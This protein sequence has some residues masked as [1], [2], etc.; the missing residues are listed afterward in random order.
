[1][2]LTLYT[3]LLYPANQHHHTPKRFYLSGFISELQRFVWYIV[4]L[5]NLNG[6]EDLLFP[7]IRIA[8]RIKQTVEWYYQKKL[9]KKVLFHTNLYIWHTSIFNIHKHICTDTSTLVNIQVF[10]YTNKNICTNT[11]GIVH[12]LVYIYTLTSIYVHT[13]VFCTHT[14][15]CVYTQIYM[16]TQQYIWTYT[17][18]FVQTPVDMYTYQYICA[19]TRICVYTEVFMC[20]HEY[21]CTH[22]SIYVH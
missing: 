3:H 13:T 22:T 12:R 14:S 15:I 7:M 20:T 9:M 17:N 11:R 8:L 5:L 18:K 4:N 2:L 6:F 19:H 16:C 1:M 10:V 21:V